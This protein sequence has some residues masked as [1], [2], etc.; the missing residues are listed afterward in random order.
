MNENIINIPNQ[1]LAN[2]VMFKL[3][4]I[5]NQFTIE[6]LTQITEITLNYNEIKE[7]NEEINLE[8]LNYFTNLKDL[9]LLN[10]SISNLDFDTFL[11][12]TKLYSLKLINC[13]FENPILIAG[14]NLTKLSLMNCNIEDCKFIY[15]IETLKKL[16]IT[17]SI[18]SL[19]QLSKLKNL[20]YL[21]LSFSTIIDIEE[22]LNLPN[23]EELTVDNTNLKDLSFI[24]NLTNLSTL[25]I[26]ETQY[27]T[28]INIIQSL[29]ARNIK[30][31]NEEIV[32]F[33]LGGD[34]NA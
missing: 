19:K 33:N 30:I 6:E 13:T 1:S 23:L 15:T 5:E 29:K 22:Q 28:N 16:T 10:F 26:D 25:S 34:Y 18:V 4:K 27:S 7:D 9:T 3:D 21:K 20:E 32:E 14:L 24:N 2:Y 12:L 11:G 31:M 8:I 17:K